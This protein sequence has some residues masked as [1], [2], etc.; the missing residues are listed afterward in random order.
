MIKFIVVISSVFLACLAEKALALAPGVGEPHS[1]PAA[2]TTSTEF[3][4]SCVFAGITPT[5][6]R[7]ALLLGLSTTTTAAATFILPSESR[8]APVEEVG[9]VTLVNLLEGLRSVPTFCIVD[10]AGAAYMLYKPGEGSARGFAFA[11]FPG[12]LAVLG[13]ALRTA[14]EGGYLDVW[15]D[16]KITTVPADIA[17]R[18]ALQPRERFTQKSEIP[19]ANS[20]LAMIPGADERD[21]AFKMDKKF[22]D[23]SK[24]PLFYFENFKA[25]NGAI[26]LYLNPLDLVNDW[27]AK[28]GGG[29]ASV[30]PPRVRVIDLLSM[31]Q[32]VLRGR[33]DELPFRGKVTFVTTSE[34][35]EMAKTLKEQGLTP[36]KTD[37]MII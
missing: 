11:S 35:M 24:V 29:S 19:K 9:V 10:P 2:E 31:F 30:I 16:A 7:D 22:K 5:S 3:R 15:K 18:L 17:V 34:A 6:R 23:Q 37:R 25:D 1:R 8:A 20:I 4:S 32:F 26:P 12:A 21:A 28:N 27:T 14:E 13:D 36:Y 33:A